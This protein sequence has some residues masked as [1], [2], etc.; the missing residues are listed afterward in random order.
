[1]KIIIKNLKL[2]LSGS[3]SFA[4]KKNQ[5]QGLTGKFKAARRR[6]KQRM[7]VIFIPGPYET[8]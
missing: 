1:L 3:S 6:S 5:I 4:I 7:K 2:I 8:A